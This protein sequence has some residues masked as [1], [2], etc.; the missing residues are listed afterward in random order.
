M[1][2]ETCL[3]KGTG[4]ALKCKIVVPST[5]QVAPC[6]W[7]CSHHVYRPIHCKA[8]HMHVMWSSAAPAAL[9]WPRPTHWEKQLQCDAAT[10]SKCYSEMKANTSRIQ[11]RCQTASTKWQ[12][13]YKTTHKSYSRGWQQHGDISH[14]LTQ[15]EEEST[16][17]TMSPSIDIRPKTFEKASQNSSEIGPKSFPNQWKWILGTSSAP[18]RA[19]V[20]SRLVPRNVRCTTL[21]LCLRKMSLR[22]LILVSP[23]KSKI[24]SKWIGIGQRD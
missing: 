23:W 21:T 2:R 4:S 16:L 9:P 18:N 10:M 6:C 24:W 14:H 1:L 8:S 20:G 5:F 13:T 11:P 12:T 22:R 7:L 3:S 17:N 15:N 19:Q